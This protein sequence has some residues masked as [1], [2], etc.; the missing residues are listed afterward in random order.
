M[1]GR[2]AAGPSL[3][4]ILYRA[5]L[6]A[7]HMLHHERGGA[8]THVLVAIRAFE[9][10]AVYDH[11]FYSKSPSINASNIFLICSAAYVPHKD[12]VRAMPGRGREVIINDN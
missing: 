8:V 3:V 2:P 5:S 11:V 7:D 9:W 4:L 1:G 6:A 10:N 12:L